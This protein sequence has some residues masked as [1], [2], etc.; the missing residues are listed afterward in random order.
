MM[1][2]LEKEDNLFNYRNYF[3]L[4]YMLL[5]MSFV[6]MAFLKISNIF[7]NFGCKINFIYYKNYTYKLG[8]LI[9][10]VFLLIEY[11]DWVS[12]LNNSSM[13]SIPDPFIL[14]VPV[15]F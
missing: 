15:N 11:S 12:S 8:L 14:M 3:L 1:L 7:L 9:S 13:F 6:D 4:S 5:G 10:I 2:Q